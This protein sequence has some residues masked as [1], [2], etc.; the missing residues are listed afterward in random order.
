M[1][2]RDDVHARGWDPTKD[3]ANRSCARDKAHKWPLGAHPWTSCHQ[4]DEWEA[5]CAEATGETRAVWGKKP[6][7]I[8]ALSRRARYDQPRCFRLF[9]ERPVVP[10]DERTI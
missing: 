7:T 6:V 3:G 1:G 4:G 9:V 2:A 5:S 8:E 10:Y